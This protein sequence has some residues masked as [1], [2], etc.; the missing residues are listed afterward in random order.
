MWFFRRAK[1]EP[2]QL[3]ALAAGG[4]LS[5]INE[6]PFDQLAS[7]CS[8]RQ[9]RREMLGE[10]WGVHDA[11]DARR[12]LEWL[13]CEGHTR[14]ALDLAQGALSPDDLRCDNPAGRATVAELHRLEIQQ[15]GLRAFDYGRMVSVARWSYTGGLLTAEEAWDWLLR[16]ARLVQGTYASW[17]EYGRGWRLGYTY[18][19]D[20]AIDFYV[21]RQL[22]WLETAA[23]SPW[24][25]IRWNEDLTAI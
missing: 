13:A 5:L 8:S 6:E 16:C 25:R 22:T 21:N 20:G 3:W 10:G 15:Y 14:E 1:L 12:I 11:D 9:C 19:C 2:W 7:R 17:P 24:R 18:W 4:P 23:K